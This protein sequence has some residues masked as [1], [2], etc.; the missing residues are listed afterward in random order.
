M[1]AAA[2]LG[3]TAC[4]V[5]NIEPDNIEIDEMTHALPLGTINFN[6]IDELVE[7]KDP[8]PMSFAN[9][10][11]PVQD[12]P[13]PSDPQA[14]DNATIVL[15]PTPSTIPLDLSAQEGIK[16]DEIALKAG[17]L[18]LF[19]SYDIPSEIALT[20][21]IPKIKDG[22]QQKFNKT[23]ILEK[24]DFLANP[25]EVSIPLAGY[26]LEPSNNEITV[27]TS[28]VVNVKKDDYITDIIVKPSMR[29]TGLKFDT[30][31]GY[32]GQ[33]PVDIDPQVIELGDMFS[34]EVTLGA[35]PV[36]KLIIENRFGIPLEADFKNVKA[37][38]KDGSTVNLAFAGSAVVKAATMTGGSPTAVRSAIEL[39]ADNSELEKLFAS[40]VKELSFGLS[41]KT[42]PAGEDLVTRNFLT[43][44]GGIKITIG[45]QIPVKIKPGGGNTDKN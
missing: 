4:E 21:E 28:G 35:K 16:V 39:N 34:K 22:N 25:K 5:P 24:G 45:V 18:Q 23:I 3:A 19:F 8:A 43:A 10:E 2:L 44:D 40:D 14:T 26:I 13:F 9:V 12:H 1:L 41:M 33:T 15:T 30:I 42:N 6:K 36:L 31:K 32:F 20:L 11:V 38:R 37:I 27:T 17:M 29:L 7:I